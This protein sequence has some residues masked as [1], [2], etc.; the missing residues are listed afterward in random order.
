MWKGESQLGTLEIGWHRRTLP[1]ATLAVA[2]AVA[3]GVVTVR[4]DQW[5]MSLALALAIGLPVALVSISTTLERRL[6]IFFSLLAVVDFGKRVVFLAP[7]QSPWSQY[8]VMILPTLYY[9]VAILVP[10]LPRIIATPLSRVEQLALLYLALALAMTWLSP[11]ATLLGRL[12][13][14]GLLL[15]PWTMILVA[16]RCGEGALRGVSRALSYWA[17]VSALYGIW[18]FFFGPTPVELGWAASVEF[19]IGAQH[20]RMAMSGEGVGG[21]WRVTGLQPDA[22][23]FGLFLLTGLIGAQVLAARGEINRLAYAAL[24]G[25][26]LLGIVLSLVRT[27]W[28]ATALFLVTRWVAERTTLLRHPRLILLGI[29]GMFLLAPTAAA[30]LYQRFT[31]LAATMPNPLLARMLTFGTLEARKDALAIF[32]DVLPE[33]LLTGLGYAISPW[34]TGKFGSQLELAPNFAEHNVIMEQLWYVGLPGLL[35]F[36]A[37][38]YCVFTGLVQLNRQG[39]QRE[40]RTMS[41]L[42][43]ALLA[44]VMTGHGNGGVFL[45]YPFF[46]ILGVLAAQRAGAAVRAFPPIGSEQGHRRP[47]G[48]AI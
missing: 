48:C 36:L 40:W 45:N 42:T 24:A 1:L 11:G 12:A 34:I 8:L 31:Y 17:V 20:L 15:L 38:I 7:G 3:S 29:V 46:F 28:V 35:L 44:L 9:G 16:A 30:F 18:L 14:S 10:A 41:I 47:Q 27:I 5:A 32:I 19:S 25:L 26:L 22:F 43:A 23:T 2:G 4:Y 13:A 6:V 21:V 33:R 37:L 39:D